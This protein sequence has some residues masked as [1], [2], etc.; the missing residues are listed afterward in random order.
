MTMKRCWKSFA[1]LAVIVCA[2]VPAPA[3][4]TTAK[5]TRGTVEGVV[6]DGIA[7]FRGIPFA[8]P[9][10]GDLRWK[11]PRPVKPWQG[12]KKADDFAPSPM[13]DT[14]FGAMLGG[15]QKISEDYLYLNV[16]TGAM[17]DVLRQSS[18]R[19]APNL[20]QLKAFD[21]CFTKLREEAKSK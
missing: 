19:K 7:S 8:A 20:D 2:V 9:P 15:P 1:V 18:R 4:I 13:Q 3:Q 12:V 6:K 14:A 16:W 17:N 10:I 11:S 5:V 21:A